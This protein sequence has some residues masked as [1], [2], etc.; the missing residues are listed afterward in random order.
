MH[1]LV[2]LIQLLQILVYLTGHA[3][4]T[5]VAYLLVN[6]RLELRVQDWYIFEKVVEGLTALVNIFSYRWCSRLFPLVGVD[7][8]LDAL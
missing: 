1:H 4:Q 3:S 7:E 5:L 2:W 8:D 6:E